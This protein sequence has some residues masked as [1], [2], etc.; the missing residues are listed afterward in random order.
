MRIARTPTTRYRARATALLRC[1]ER[2]RD[3]L[4]AEPSVFSEARVSA[5]LSTRR[6]DEFLAGTPDVELDVVEVEYEWEA[7]GLR[8]EVLVEGYARQS[9]ASRALVCATQ[10]AVALADAYPGDSA[11]L[12]IDDV[13]VT[14]DRGAGKDYSFDPSVRVATLSVS[15]A[16]ASGHKTDRAGKI[17]RDAIEGLSGHGV[18]LEA[19]EVVGDRKDVVSKRV[20]E[21]V[22]DGI[23]MIAT[24]GGT[25]LTHTDVT[26]S[27][28]EPLIEREIPGL[29]EAL[30]D[31]GLEQT[32]LAYISRGIAGLID[33][34][35]VLTLPGSSSGAQEA[36][37][38]IF[39]SVLH[40]FH[41]L[42]RSRRH[43]K[44][45]GE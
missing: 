25:G 35:L 5:T 23:E 8:I 44:G 19:S 43:L 4:D 12:E 39:P 20:R 41:V 33:D 42:R 45:D 30:R 26:V 32:P 2:A 17:V 27:A 6:A 13:R 40:V 31:Y 29:M 14:S 11:D 3:V 9:I 1:D 7:A 16:V 18:I 37:E 34:T 15:D 10:F 28:I 24:V 21:W 22:D 36:I 38:A